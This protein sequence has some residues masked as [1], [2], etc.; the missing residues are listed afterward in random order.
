VSAS[1]GNAYLADSG[2]PAVLHILGAVESAIPGIQR[3]RAM[4]EFLMMVQRSLHT[5][6]VDGIAL[7]SIA[8]S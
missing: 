2:L 6:G 7:Q 3:G 1:L 8:L 5:G 4:K